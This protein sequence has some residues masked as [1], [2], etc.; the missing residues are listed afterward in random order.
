M[1]ITV[2]SRHVEV[3]PGVRSTTIEKV[4]RLSKY[5]EGMDR[6]EV[7]FDEEHNRRIA[8]SQRCE[9]TMFGH[10]HVVRTK[11]AAKDQLA[12]VDLAV[13]KLEQQLTRLNRRLVSRSQGKVHGTAVGS[14]AL[15][16]ESEEATAEALL[17]LLDPVG[18]S[19]E[20]NGNGDGDGH[21]DGLR[22][23]KIVKSKRFVLR[24]MSPEEAVLQLELVGHHFY[25]FH[26][27]EQ[28]GTAVV[29]RREDGDYGLI[30]V[31][32]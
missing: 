19:A 13:D 26:H 10:G 11:V 9:V 28:G 14:G 3:P 23:P 16:Q 21:G 6:A 25:V 27:A 17:E 7:V 29:Y 1:D 18:T 30:Q 4:A 2:S 15:V 5:L 12:A 8:Q 22:S 20:A 32:G 24:P 31:A